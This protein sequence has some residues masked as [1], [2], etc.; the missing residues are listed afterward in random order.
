MQEDRVVDR[1]DRPRRWH[2]GLWA[3]GILA[4]LRGPNGLEGR[5]LTASGEGRPL[6]LVC[7]QA[8]WHK[9][10]IRVLESSLH[11]EVYAA[12]RSSETLRTARALSY[13]SQPIALVIHELGHPR[14]LSLLRSSLPDVP[15]ITIGN[16]GTLEERL[17]AAANGA[18]A[19]LAQPV[20]TSEIAR[21]AH[22][23]LHVSADARG[24]PGVPIPSEWM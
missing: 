11:A 17:R 2:K 6:V 15:L 16:R 12:E 20:R 14:V 8:R 10:L 5:A 24:L 22:E 3:R 18:D 9:P 23:I 4:G 1:V 13:K 19:F 7:C 21:V